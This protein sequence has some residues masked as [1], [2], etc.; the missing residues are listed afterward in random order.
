M[1]IKPLMFYTLQISKDLQ[2]TKSSHSSMNLPFPIH[3]GN[4]ALSD[5][6]HIAHAINYKSCMQEG[7]A[8]T[9][10]T[11]GKRC[12]NNWNTCGGKVCCK[13]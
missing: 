2:L 10:P 13:T 9:C 1:C 11:D 3:L 8:L 5:S 12:S 6:V 7:Y 4:L